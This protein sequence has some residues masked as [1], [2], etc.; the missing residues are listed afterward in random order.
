MK[1]TLRYRIAAS[2][3]P[4]L[5]F[6]LLVCVPGRLAAQLDRGEITGTAED[7]SHAVVPN[8]RI[9]LTN[10]DTGVTTTTKSTSTGTYVFDD[11]VPGKYSLEA[12]AGG[13]AESIW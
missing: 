1:A 8:A 6:F 9:V 10:V 7:P 5:G 3:F 2:L 11:V 4:A 12:E 13:F